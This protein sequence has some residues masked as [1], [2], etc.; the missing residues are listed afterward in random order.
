MSTLPPGNPRIPENINRSATHPLKEFLALLVGVTLGLILLAF[1]IGLLSHWL[2]P[3]IPFSWEN[4]A[5]SL[6]DEAV[7][8]EFGDAQFQPGQQQ[9]LRQLGEKLVRA[10]RAAADARGT[11]AG[12]EIPDEAFSFRLVQSDMANAFASFGGHIFVTDALVTSLSSENALAMVLSHEIAH[13]RHRDPIKSSSSALMLQITMSAVLG[14]SGQG[15][16]R[17]FLASTGLV[18]MTRFSRE[19]ERDSDQ[20][21]LATLVQAYGHSRGA[22]EFFLQIADEEDDLRWLEFTETHPDTLE[23]LVLIEHSIAATVP[24][25]E[26]PPALTP[27]PEALQQ[28]APQE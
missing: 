23:R 15:F 26:D 13:V 22:D 4:T 16:L 7:E 28:V 1:V 10:D 18:T 27:L 17:Q 25:P 21:G 24:D 12:S 9:A 11:A 5:A 6:V 20:R 2:A 19:M 3:H 14:Y 8:E